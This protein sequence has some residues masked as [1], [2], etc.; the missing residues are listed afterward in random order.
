MVIVLPPQSPV[1]SPCASSHPPWLK[2]PDVRLPDESHLSINENNCTS[3]GS[4][5]EVKKF[6]VMR[7]PSGRLVGLIIQHHNGDIERLGRGAP[8]S[9]DIRTPLSFVDLYDGENDGP[10]EWITVLS[11]E[12]WQSAEGFDLRIGRIRDT[13]RQSV[14]WPISSASPVFSFDSIFHSSLFPISFWTL[15][16]RERSGPLLVD[17]Y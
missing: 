3:V 9:E 2:L 14:S 4:L 7:E 5:L 8:L 12:T 15:L 17:D 6:Q 16:T 13:E 11:V 10:L 1:P